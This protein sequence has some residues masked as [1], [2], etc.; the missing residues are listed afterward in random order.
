MAWALVGGVVEGAPRSGWVLFFGFLY[1]RVSLSSW[2]LS[3]APT[4]FALVGIFS[5]YVCLRNPNHRDP[6]TLD[7]DWPSHI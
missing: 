2:G 4:V 5:K 1:G 3:L 7:S 6:L